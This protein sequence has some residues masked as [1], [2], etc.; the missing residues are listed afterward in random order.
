VWQQAFEKRPDF[1]PV[2]GKQ[3]EPFW[4]KSLFLT[5][6]ISLWDEQKT[7]TQLHVENGKRL[8][9]FLALR[10]FVDIQIADC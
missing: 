5:N 2:I 6:T 9:S 3:D 8:A 7:L 4:Q 10:S 1:Q